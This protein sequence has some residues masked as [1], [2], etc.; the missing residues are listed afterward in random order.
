MPMLTYVGN[1]GRYRLTNSDVDVAQGETVTVDDETAAHL[2][3]HGEFEPAEDGSE[4]PSEDDD[5]DPVTA[6]SF[7]DGEELADLTVDEVTA[8]LETGDYDQALDDIRSAEEH[9]KDRT[10]VHDAI[11]TRLED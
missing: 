2:L 10:T 3:E 6:F 4:A 1:A 7:S 8:R 9:G 5:E 11:D